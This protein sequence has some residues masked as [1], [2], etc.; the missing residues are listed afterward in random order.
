[1]WCSA[2]HLA[3]TCL[4]VPLL[5]T[6]YELPTWEAGWTLFALRSFFVELIS[7]KARP[8][9]LF[10]NGLVIPPYYRPHL[11]HLQAPDHNN[12]QKPSVIYLRHF[13][14]VVW[15]FSIGIYRENDSGT[16]FQQAPSKTLILGVYLILSE[17]WLS[18]FS[19]KESVLYVFFLSIVSVYRLHCLTCCPRAFAFHRS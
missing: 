16:H 17:F 15:K 13:T 14:A 6:P 8:H 11:K 3:S 18:A 9:F 2:D 5:M 7:G 10:P 4:G 12:P 1:M 19:E